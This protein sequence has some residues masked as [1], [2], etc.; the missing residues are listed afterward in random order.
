LKLIAPEGRF[1]RAGTFNEAILGRGVKS[2]GDYMS[3]VDDKLVVR[4]VARDIS[5]LGYVSY[6]TYLAHRAELKA[7][8]IG[9]PGSAVA[10][11]AE[12]ISSGAYAPLSRPLFLYVTTKALQNQSVDRFVDLMLANG[13][14]LSEA[15]GYV[16]FAS[17]TY[18]AARSRLAHRS[19][20][21]LWAGVVPVGL[22]PMQL[23]KRLAAL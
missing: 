12:T 16:P 8:A 10:P 17:S 20:G 13:V 4:G 15:V 23:E 1:E 18:A 6:A 7:V 14:R 21:S 2:R 9:S 19:T 22:T 3:T 11:S 5:A